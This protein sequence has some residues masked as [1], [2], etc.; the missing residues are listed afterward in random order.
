MRVGAWEE[1][2]ETRVLLSCPLHRSCGCPISSKGEK[3]SLWDCAR[4]GKRPLWFACARK[5]KR[6]LIC[7]LKFYSLL[8]ATTNQWWQ[9][10]WLL[11]SSWLN[12]HL[13]SRLRGCGWCP[14]VR[15]A[16][17][18]TS[19]RHWWALVDSNVSPL[20]T[21]DGTHVTFFWYMSLFDLSCAISSKL[22]VPTSATVSQP[23]TMG[24]NAYIFLILSSSQGRPP[25]QS[26]VPPKF[27]YFFTVGQL[28]NHCSYLDFQL[29]NKRFSL[30]FIYKEKQFQTL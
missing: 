7:W 8:W 6:P 13:I 19:P 10:S 2:R 17:P 16:I 23:P 9:D 15:V 14:M 26:P 25:R 27:G 5:G 4:K 11:L 1:I 24:L 18:T 22:Q 28:S 21:P 29:E 20:R 30:P 3:R 12:Q